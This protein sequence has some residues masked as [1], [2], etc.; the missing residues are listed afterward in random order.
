[1]LRLLRQISLRQL[2]ASWGRTALVI[3]GISTGVSLIVAINIINHSVREN[4]RRTIELAAG[5]AALEVTLGVGEIG[6]PEAAVETVRNDLDVTAAIALVRGT[7][8][9]AADPTETL[10]LYGVDLTAEQDIGRYQVT[11]AT[12]RKEIVRALAEPAT[13]LLAKSFADT[14]RVAVGD[15]VRLSTPA[16]IKALTVRGLLKTA[17]LADA[18]GGRLAVMD[19]AGAQDLFQKDGRVD[20]IDV[21][22]RDG[23]DVDAVA[24]HLSAALPPSLSVARPA[25]RGLQYDRIVASFQAML[26]ALSALALVVGVYIIYNST[27]TGAIHRQL[28]MAHLRLI[29][30]EGAQLFRLFMCEALALGVLGVGIGIPIGIVLAELLTGMVSDSM[31]VIFQL[32]FPIVDLRV[33]AGELLFI[34]IL[35]IGAALFASYFAARRVAALDPLAVLRREVFARGARP[36][37]RRFFMLWLLLVGISIAALAIQVRLRS[38]AWGNFGSTVWNASVFVIAIPVVT[39]TAAALS[40]LLPRVFGVEGRVAAAGLFRVPARTGVTVAAVA[41]VLTIG[42]TVASLTVSFQRSVGSYYEEGG[43]LLGD[44]VVSAVATEGGWLESP[45]PERV[46]DEVRA[47]PGVRAVETWRAQYGQL[48]RGERVALFALS[49][50][51]FDPRTYGSRWYFAGDPVHAADALRRGEGVNVSVA[52]ADRFGLHVGDAIE[53]ATPTGILSLP[54]V[55]IVADYIS[56]RGAIVLRR[57][58]YAERWQDPTVSRVHV[59]TNPDVSLETVRRGITGAIGH[60]HLVKMLSLRDVVRDLD[61]KIDRAFAFTDAIQLLIIIVTIAGILDL[62]VAGILERRRELAVWRL[63]G[64]DD[65]AVRRAIVIE[66]GTIGGL[67]AALGLVVGFVTAWIW[68]S[69]NYRYILGFYLQYHLAEWTALWY[70]VLIVTAT[71]LAGFAA[72]YRA[73]RQSVLAGIQLD[74]AGGLPGAGEGLRPT[75]SG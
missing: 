48:Y 63:I 44:L 25:Q 9:L 55:G 12:D 18:L 61:E 31:G 33:D 41:G 34:A 51:F 52:L 2:R 65:G 26:T 69:I 73:T 71:M 37:A 42:I 13:V 50:G 59:F 67:G 10:Q 11:A 32:R 21:V 62:L 75:T 5:P 8:A 20:Q 60:E 56:D 29:G 27:S 70:V 6:F 23:A 19:I 64:A 22:V 53:L 30:A 43:F 35:G 1:M 68:V 47:V 66:A 46:A 58:L 45:L 39:W 4:F 49:D 3:G 28:A 16:G 24:Q 57:R 14:H 40:R 7:V 74:D 72:A 17:G 15:A 38:L 54:I 36:S